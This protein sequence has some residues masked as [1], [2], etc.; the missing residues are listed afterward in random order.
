[1]FPKASFGPD[2]WRAFEGNTHTCDVAALH[3]LLG[4]VPIISRTD[5]V[6]YKRRH[7]G[8]VAL[9]SVEEKKRRKPQFRHTMAPLFW[10]QSD[11]AKRVFLLLTY[12]LQPWSQRSPIHSCG[13]PRGHRKP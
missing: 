6:L 7:G 5:T 9:R 1:M 10:R 8:N 13:L 11:A 3:V 12:P 2:A 4:K